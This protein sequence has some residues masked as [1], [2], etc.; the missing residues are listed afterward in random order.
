MNVEEVQ[1]RLW[2]TE[3]LESVGKP[4]AWKP[5]RPVWGWGR[6]VSPCPTP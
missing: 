2:E 1:R 3:S 5:A 6:G 4:D